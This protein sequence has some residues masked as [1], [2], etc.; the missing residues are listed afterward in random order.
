ML[1][2]QL[3]AWCWFAAG[4]FCANTS[5]AVKLAAALVMLH[6]LQDEYHSEHHSE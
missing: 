2:Q 3:A 5:N 6:I 1:N 4:Q